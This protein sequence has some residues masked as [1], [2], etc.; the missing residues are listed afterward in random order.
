MLGRL[1]S[2]D[3]EGPRCACARA[4]DRLEDGPPA[5]FRRLRSEA[6]S[7]PGR[8][9]RG[10]PERDPDSGRITPDLGLSPTSGRSSPVARTDRPPVKRKPG[11]GPFPSPLRRIRRTPD[12]MNAFSTH[13]PRRH[14]SRLRHR[15]FRLRSRLFQVSSPFGTSRREPTTSTSRTA[16]RP[17]RD[18]AATANGP[19]FEALRHGVFCELGR[20]GVD[21]PAV[22]A[23]FEE[24]AYSRLRAGG[25]GR[26]SRHGRARESARRNREYLRSIE[27]D[28]MT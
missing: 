5:L 18:D 21:F 1:R 7:G 11:C 10:V 27:L 17:S 13:R 16:V 22:L 2:G 12:E 19:T 24:T 4:F 26:S 15:P 20:G 8:Q 3:A 23:W 14:R 6:L 28:I 9:E 25:T